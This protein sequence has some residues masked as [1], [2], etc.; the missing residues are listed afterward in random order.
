VDNIRDPDRHPLAALDLETFKTVGEGLN[1]NWFGGY[2]EQKMVVQS[3]KR[4]C[5]EEEGESPVSSRLR[6]RVCT[7][8]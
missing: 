7:Q 4:A 3:K 6:K 1:G 2:T 5:E 8:Y